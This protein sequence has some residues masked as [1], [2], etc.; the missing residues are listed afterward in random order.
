MNRKTL[1]KGLLLSIG[2]LSIQSC[3]KDFNTI[4]SGVIGD[5]N[6]L[7]D[8]YTASDIVAYNQVTGDGTRPGPVETGYLPYN[9]IGAL[10]DPTFGL[11][12]ASFVT[13]VALPT[14]NSLANLGKNPKV[15]SVYVYVPYI[16]GTSETIND[17]RKYD[18]PSTYGTGSFNLK[19]YENGYFL[20]N[21]SPDPN[22]VNRIYSDEKSKIE[23][24][25]KGTPAGNPLNDSNDITQNTSFTFKNTPINLYK[26]RADG[27]IQT[28]ETTGK[29]LIKQTLEPGMWVDLNKAYFEKILF[30]PENKDNL[31]NNNLFKNFFRG[32]Y[33][34]AES[35]GNTGTIGVMNFAQAK[36]VVV[37]T[38]DSET[39]G[40]NRER[41]VLEFKISSDVVKDGVTDNTLITGNFFKNDYHAT[42][43]QNISNPNKTQGDEKLFLKG[44]SGSFAVIELFKK[45]NN[46]VSEELEYLRK[47]KWLINDAR[48]TFYVD[49]ATLANGKQVEP[50]RIYLYD[51]DNNM[52]LRDYATD[53]TPQNALYSKAVYGGVLEKESTGDKKGIRYR[54]KIADHINNLINKDST[55]VKLGLVVSYDITNVSHK[56]LK[57]PI[58]N[59]PKT[60]KVIPTS[61]IISP[62]GT[63]LYGSNYADED[64]KMKLEIFY[65]KSKNQ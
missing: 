6:F 59:T 23:N 16:L 39:V 18:L 54:I 13:Q 61:S 2:A 1:L 26:Y 29:P 35:T 60:I 32:L 41:K 33:F 55:N 31:T 57:N 36:L 28:D 17:E 24:F 15:D 27:S 64:K 51:L 58:A 56:R 34:K 47:N 46:G 8:K 65:T 45:N 12:E 25:I 21:F 44:G 62:L 63:V 53:N 20:S 37:Y 5:E 42:Y 10:S 14:T 22:N 48:F 38:Q 50:T 43:L 9:T 19:I 30:S 49:K 40:K 4:G 52:I 3:D 7:M 11:T